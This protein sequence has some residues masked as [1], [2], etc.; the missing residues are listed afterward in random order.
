[1][2]EQQRA[3]EDLIRKMQDATATTE[4]FA[5]ANKAAE[6]ALTQYAKT[7]LGEVSR[8]VAAF[9]GSVMKGER[10]FSTLTPVVT[11][12]GNAVSS[13]A[14]AIPFLGGVLGKSVQGVTAAFNFLTGE[15]DST[16]S[17][18]QDI[19]QVGALGA[20]GLSDF[21]KMAA[22]SMLSLKSFSQAIQTNSQSL[23]AFGGATF[24]ATQ[25]FATAVGQIADRDG[26]ARRLGLSVQDIAD[27]TGDFMKMQ[28]T[29]GRQQMFTGDN[30]RLG[31][32][33][34]IL[35]L[36][37]LARLTGRSVKDLRDN[38]MQLLVDQR[39]AG[40]ASQMEDGGEMI[41]K[42]ITGFPPELQAGIKDVI[43]SGGVA[44]TEAGREILLRGSGQVINDLARSVRSEADITSAL[45]Q[46]RQ[47]FADTEDAFAGAAAV[48]VG[49][50]QLFGIMRQFSNR[51]MENQESID[52]SRQKQID[53]T[54]ALVKKITDAAVNLD[55]FNIGLEK[56]IM[57][58]GLPLVAS[59]IEKLSG[60]LVDVIDFLNNALGAS[61]GAIT[62]V[63]MT[64]LGM[65]EDNSAIEQNLAGK[66]VNRATMLLKRDMSLELKKIKQDLQAQGLDPTLTADHQVEA[67]KK[68]LQSLDKDKHIGGVTP[69]LESTLKKMFGVQYQFGGIA[70]GPKTG[71]M[72]QLHGTEAIVP[73]PDGDS[74]PVEM[75]PGTSTTAPATAP[76]MDNRQQLEI[77]QTQVSRLDE[78][79][80]LM[81]RQI[82]ATDKVRTAVS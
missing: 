48:G 76:G 21:R 2:D 4:D 25:D 63:E 36:D 69:A 27:T 66:N 10:S 52:A 56:L 60:V 61:P 35:Q 58:K 19:S 57:E 7:T 9:S 59:G 72:A 37:T 68:A 42:F 17:A 47:M 11:A 30:L 23:A 73:L 46:V 53:G 3:L 34:Y 77:M 40:M 1:M 74:I 75:Q 5:R 44:T 6:S 50:T 45:D 64:S 79:I 54:D 82:S 24:A 55:L 32:E 14:K 15:L 62:K 38:Q 67:F 13:A 29:A 8:G 81:G 41:N 70:T 18:F 28:A 78:M 31:T 22:Q 26:F 49:P 33:A 65:G 12:L 39:F 20:E 51:I 80:R 71:Y 16:F 43:T